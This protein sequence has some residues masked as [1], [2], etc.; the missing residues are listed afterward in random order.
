MAQTPPNQIP[1][2]TETKLWV[3]RT[4]LKER[5]RRDIELQLADADVRFSPADRELT[6]CLADGLA[7]R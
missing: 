3:M 2:I 4:T 5:Y 1:D 7:V 6:P